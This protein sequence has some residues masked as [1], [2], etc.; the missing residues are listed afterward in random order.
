MQ[1]STQRSLPQHLLRDPEIRQALAART[2]SAVF[3]AA[4]AAGL[5][6]YAIG[7][8]IGVKAERVA[9]VA[10]G[11]GAITGIDTIERIADGLHIPGAMLGLAKRYWECDP[12]APAAREEDPV[13][14]RQLLRGALGASTAVPLTGVADVLKDMEQ[15]LAYSGR[16]DVTA[17]EVAAERH[18]QG[19]RGRD[20]D[21]VLSDLINEM[22]RAVPLLNLYHPTSVRSDLA[23]AIGQIGGLTAIVLHDQGRGAEALQWFATA[24]EAA[25][26]SGDRKLRAWILGRRA[27]VP[28]N[29]GA[30]QIAAR[31][32]EQARH[33][34]GS[35]NS[36]AAALAASVAARSYAMSNQRARATAAL[37]DA[38]RIS[39][40]LSATESSATWFGYCPQK[41]QVHRSQALTQL[42]ETRAARQ[43]QN[44][45]LRL[46]S[47]AGMTYTLLLLDAAI[48]QH[49]DGDSTGA[50]A[51]AAD[52]LAHAPEPYRAGL[53]RQRGVELYRGLPDQ[54][55]RASSGRRLATVLREMQPRRA[56]PES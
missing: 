41:H 43:S 16:Q 45:G 24:A 10:R 54:T 39:G 12:P 28:L 27:M 23:R 7:D 21:D 40:S 31:I 55:Q 38:D 32:A 48:C 37:Q 5:S 42:G 33:V 18:S 25:K 6:Y 30:P 9:E 11:K 46:T 34:A 51:R 19:Y 29:Y 56:T 8:A 26:Q 3:A 53:V 1:R 52:I 50:C 17:V 15:A 14:R 49:H 47:P 20:P 35:G 22:A 13:E 2:F 44:A 36:A 4:K